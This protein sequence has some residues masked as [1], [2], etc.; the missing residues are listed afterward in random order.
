M[1]WIKILLT[2]G[3][4]PKFEWD[5]VDCRWEVYDDGV[6]VFAGPHG[7]LKEAWFF[8]AS[9]IISVQEYTP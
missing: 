3:D 1:R 4:C 5:Q 2:N 8:P 7:K 9:N 6:Q